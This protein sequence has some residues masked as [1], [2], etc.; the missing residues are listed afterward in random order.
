MSNLRKFL[1][2]SY[3]RVRYR[4]LVEPHGRAFDKSRFLVPFRQ[5]LHPSRPMAL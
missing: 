4:E 1:Q 3:N 5:F 2:L